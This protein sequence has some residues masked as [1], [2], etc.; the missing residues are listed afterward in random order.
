MNYGN[1]YVAS[2]AINM[3]TAMTDQKVAVDSGQ[4]LLYR[5]NPEPRGAG[6]KSADP[7]FAHSN[8]AGFGNPSLSPLVVTCMS[9]QA[10]VFVFHRG[11]TDVSFRNSA[12]IS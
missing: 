6:E 12:R 2:V 10:E 1:V 4:W 11:N 8:Q 3:T 7:G 9:V 5:Y